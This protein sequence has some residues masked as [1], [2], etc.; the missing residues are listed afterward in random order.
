MHLV[1]FNKPEHKSLRINGIVC[2]TSVLLYSSNLFLFLERK[3]AMSSVFPLIPRPE[4]QVIEVT[5]CR[6]NSCA[7]ASHSKRRDRPHQALLDTT[8]TATSSPDDACKDVFLHDKPAQPKRKPEKSPDSGLKAQ[9]SGFKNKMKELSPKPL[10][11]RNIIRVVDV[12]GTQSLAR[13]RKDAYHISSQQSCP[14]DRSVDYSIEDM[15]YNE[16]DMFGKR[17][18]AKRHSLDH[19]MNYS[20]QRKLSSKTS[21][22][23]SVKSLFHISKSDSKMEK[24]ELS[25]SACHI[26]QSSDSMVLDLL[27]NKTNSLDRSAMLSCTRDIKA[28]RKVSKSKRQKAD[29]FVDT[30]ERELVGI[31]CLMSPI[32]LLSNLGC[33]LD[34]EC[35]VSIGWEPLFSDSIA[36]SNS[37]RGLD[38]TINFSYY[39]YLSALGI[40]FMNAG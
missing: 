23:S 15:D 6:Q 20:Q 29:I 22:M 10:H 36:D 16:N 25:E 27:Y 34:L 33:D 11:R 32:L 24:Q 1:P 12:V 17:Y 14:M 40:K 31:C 13:S 26:R 39:E 5:R 18:R 4:P 9:F 38:L 21:L 19:L 30:H 8:F 28:G 7:D 35:E 3:I 2:I 37:D